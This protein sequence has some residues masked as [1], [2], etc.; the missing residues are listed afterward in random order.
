M[1]ARG[2]ESV[3]K[4]IVISF[5]VIAAVAAISLTAAWMTST[6]F[7]YALTILWILLIG[8][9]TFDYFNHD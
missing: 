7:G 4:Y 6:I 9:I 1:V 2:S 8:V 5:I 3:N